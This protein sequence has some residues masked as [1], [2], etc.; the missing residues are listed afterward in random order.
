M[1]RLTINRMES[2]EELKNFF[3]NI[4]QM[5]K[6][7]HDGGLEA[8]IKNNYCKAY[9]VR[10]ETKELV[11][12]FALSFDSLRLDTDDIEDLQN[13]WSD[14]STP[15]PSPDYFETF[16]SKTHYPAIEISYLAVDKKYQR[17]HIGEHIIAKIEEKARSQ[18]LAGCQFLTVGALV[19]PNY[20]AVPFYTACNFAKLDPTPTN[21][22]LRM[23]H[24][25]LTK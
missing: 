1:E 8:S 20:S 3:C 25:L 22:V 9:T 19:L 6:F 15:Q 16:W 12:F 18:N 24:N 5:D 14:T 23:Y 2:M 7:I 11:A 13:G 17:L 21:E 4:P 10:N